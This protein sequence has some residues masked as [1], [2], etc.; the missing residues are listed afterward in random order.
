MLRLKVKRFKCKKCGSLRIVTYVDKIKA[1]SCLIC[2]LKKEFLKI[3][4]KRRNNVS[5]KKRHRRP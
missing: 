3:K 5:D 4:L 1:G 2:D